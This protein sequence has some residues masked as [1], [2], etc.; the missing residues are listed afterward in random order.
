MF[1]SYYCRVIVRYGVLEVSLYDNRVLFHDVRRRQTGTVSG[2]ALCGLWWCERCYALCRH[3][4]AYREFR[5]DRRHVSVDRRRPRKT[6]H[7]SYSKSMLAGFAGTWFSAA[8]L[9]MGHIYRLNCMW[10]TIHYRDVKRASINR[11]LNLKA[12]IDFASR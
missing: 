5:C 10:L 11:C 12:M 1:S 7:C 4:V 3:D 6:W 9:P 8:R 2:V